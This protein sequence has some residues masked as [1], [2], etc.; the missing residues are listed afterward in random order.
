MCFQDGEI[1]I[2][3]FSYRSLLDTS[4]SFLHSLDPLSTVTMM[5]IRS[6]QFALLL[7]LAACVSRSRVMDV[8]HGPDW[9]N[10]IM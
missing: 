5:M 1:G 4:L 7:P 10:V 9:G 8:P 3:W 2:A 6:L